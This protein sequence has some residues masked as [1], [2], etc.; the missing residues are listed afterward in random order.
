MAPMTSHCAWG[1]LLG[2]TV[3]LLSV[4]CS[5]SSKP[6]VDAGVSDDAPVADVGAE[7]VGD[8]PTTGPG[9]GKDTAAAGAPDVPALC[10]GTDQFG[11][12][13]PFVAGATPFPDGVE[14]VVPS[15][16]PTIM[17]VTD[18]ELYWAN[19]HTIHRVNFGDGV[20]KV[21]L[22]RSS[23]DNSIGGLAVDATNFYFTEVGLTKE[24]RVAKM[25]LDGSSSP[26]TLGGSNSPWQI[27][28]AGDYV[29]YYDAQLS[30]IDRLPI[31]GGNA[32]TLVRI[33]S[34]DAF[35]LANGHIYFTAQV[36]PVQ[37]SLLSISLDAQAIAPIDGGAAGGAG[38]LVTLASNNAGIRGPGFDG[39]NLFYVDGGNVMRMPADSGKATALQT[40][41][42]ASGGSIT[43]GGG[44]VYW[45][46]G[47]QSCPNVVRA[48]GD[49]SGQTILVHSIESPRKFALNATH[50][51]VMTGSKQI[52][53]VPR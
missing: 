46:T 1:F 28:V 19:R 12:D 38:G 23:L 43:A 45:T 36:T 41:Y 52:L 39:G 30:E 25:P 16:D 18:S 31:A 20:D 14:L 9:A 42:S 51:F 2:S 13:R 5:S 44:H 48:A 8:T 29:Y 7:R 21:I 49:G 33:V 53:R 24:Y 22:D 4:G 11:Y 10:P 34:P 32:T 47:T 17:L 6:T 27:A 15:G 40:Q 35:C 26:V 50:L 37:S 3:T